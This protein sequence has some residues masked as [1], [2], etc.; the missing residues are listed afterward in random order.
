[1]NKRRRQIISLMTLLIMLIAG[2]A[3]VLYLIEPVD[4]SIYFNHILRNKTAANHDRIDMVFIGASRTL[5]TFDP[6][7]FENI[8]GLDC[9]FN[10]SSGLQPIEAGYYMLKEITERYHPKYAVLGVTWEGLIEPD[11]TLAKV[12]VLDRLNG[13]NKFDYLKNGFTADEYLNAL[14][15]C[16][17][18]RNNFTAETIRS[19]I[20][21]KAELRKNGWS[22]RLSP[23]DLYTDNGFIYSYQTGDIPN[24]GEV[25]YDPGRID[26]K[27]AELLEKIADFCSENGIR[28]FLV[29]A[30]TTM[31]N[32]YRISEYQEA[33]NYY[34]KF[35][36]EHG[37]DYINLNYLKDR[38]EW[39]GDG[40]MFD[41]NHVNGEGAELVSEKYAEYLNA[42][43]N[44]RDTP[45]LF[46]NDLNE[47]QETVH[48][49]I[50][51]GA[52]IYIADL[53]AEVHISSRQT[54]GIAP[55]YR[56]LISQDDE[57]FIPLTEWTEQKD[58]VFDV[59]AYH[60]TVHFLIEAVSPTGEPGCTIKYHVPV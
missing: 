9:V 19:I 54:D 21:D 7:V 28:L 45:D 33:V 52:N 42:L 44:G 39:L 29:S 16:Y 50:A 13:K 43:I 47:L 49:I 36:A 1:M 30:P 37:S 5:R 46:Y 10:A 12:I 48:R 4:Y 11:S 18:F 38:E 2:R 55:L 60:G 34:S 20:T 41:F 35:A 58:H 23:P 59:S 57:N 25:R 27:K 8:L 15:L 17:R 24:Y 22:Q 3:L 40:L 56:V 26:P 51:V 53:K 32:L 31:M 14:S 6:E